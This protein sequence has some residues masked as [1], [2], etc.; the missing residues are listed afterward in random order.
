MGL[1]RVVSEKKKN[2]LRGIY[3]L[4]NASKDDSSAFLVLPVSAAFHVQEVL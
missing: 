1:E 4:K 3:Q 2:N